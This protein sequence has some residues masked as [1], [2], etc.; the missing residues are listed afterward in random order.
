MPNAAA[1]FDEFLGCFILMLVILAAT[2]KRN[3][4]PPGLLPLALFLTLF[5]LGVC[6]GMQT[7]EDLAL[8]FLL[9]C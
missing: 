2:D 5:G 8:T 4:P 6:F 9:R 3:S 7:G 1:F